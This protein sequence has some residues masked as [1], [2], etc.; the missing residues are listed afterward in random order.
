MRRQIWQLRFRPEAA[1]PSGEPPTFEVKSGPG[2]VVLL[3]GDADIAVPG[4]ASYVTTVT[5][6]DETA[7]LERGTLTLDGGTLELSTIGTGVLEPGLDA[8]SLRG[9]V[10]WRLEG[11]GRWAGVTGMLSS[12]FG[13]HPEQGTVVEDQVAHLYYP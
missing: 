3:D 11:T 8:G 7:L 13:G 10:I 6:L 4:T 12:V 5:M 2:T 9:A 1:P